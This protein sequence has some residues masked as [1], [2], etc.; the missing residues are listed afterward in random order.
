MISVFYTYSFILVHSV[1]SATN[2]VNHFHGAWAMP[3]GS[4][5]VVVKMAAAAVAHAT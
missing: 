4:P 5:V 3:C 2:F 1:K